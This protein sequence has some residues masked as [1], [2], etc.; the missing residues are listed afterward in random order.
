MK[1]VNLNNLSRAELEA[2]ESELAVAKKSRAEAE[3]RGVRDE[4]YALLEKK[5][6]T[7]GQVFG[8]AQG[9]KTGPVKAKYRNSKNPSDTW[10]GRGRRPRWLEA[11]LKKGR[12][13]KS[14]LIK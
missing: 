4:V 14:F 12:S 2:L 10:T 9:R 1:K 13:L 6:L 3:V 7:F 5:G 11:E 8:K